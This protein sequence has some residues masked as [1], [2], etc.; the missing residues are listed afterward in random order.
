MFCTAKSRLSTAVFPSSKHMTLFLNY[1]CMSG[2]VKYLYFPF[3]VGSAGQ[4]RDDAPV[5]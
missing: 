5:I 3:I 4:F 1:S 2:S